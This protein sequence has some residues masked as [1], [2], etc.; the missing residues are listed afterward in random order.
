MM[1][2]RIKRYIKQQLYERQNG[3]CAYCGEKKRIRLMTIDHIVPLAHGGTDKIKNL[4]CTCKKCNYLKGEM[5]PSEFTAFISRMLNNS[6]EIEKK[7]QKGG[8]L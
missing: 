4:Q 6:M 3:R 8:A 5:I 7:L 1:N 2:S